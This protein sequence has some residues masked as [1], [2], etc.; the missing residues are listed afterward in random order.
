MTATEAGT[1]C[2]ASARPR[3]VVTIISSRADAVTGASTGK[4][5]AITVT[6]AISR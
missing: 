6:V 5:I 4:D 3:A 1:S 2:T